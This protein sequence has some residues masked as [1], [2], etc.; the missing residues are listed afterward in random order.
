M[1]QSL[2]SAAGALATL[3]GSTQLSATSSGLIVT[4]NPAKLAPNLHATPVFN[5]EKVTL[6]SQVVFYLNRQ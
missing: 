5:A 6:A 4:L 2:S 3:Q 1:F